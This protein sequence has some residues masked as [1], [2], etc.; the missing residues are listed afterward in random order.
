M[1][2]HLRLHHNA[3]VCQ[4]MKKADLCHLLS[5]MSM[6]T[7]SVVFDLTRSHEAGAVAVVYEILEMLGNSYICS[8]KYDSTALD[9]PPLNLIV[10]ANFPPDSTALSRDRWDINKIITV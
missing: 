7:T 9:L 2:N 10:F 8:G 3:V 5:K 6:T 4:M 1:A